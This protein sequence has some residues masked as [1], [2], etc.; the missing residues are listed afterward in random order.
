MLF[1]WLF[2]KWYRQMDYKKDDAP[3]NRKRLLVRRASTPAPNVYM[4]RPSLERKRITAPAKL[5]VTWE[6]V[7]TSPCSSNQG[8]IKGNRELS[9]QGTSMSQNEI[10]LPPLKNGMKQSLLNGQ[11]DLNAI[12]KTRFTRRLSLAE[13]TSVTTNPFTSYQRRFSSPCQ[14]SWKRDHQDEQTN[15]M[16]QFI[17]N[18]ETNFD[19]NK[20]KAICVFNWLS[21]QNSLKECTR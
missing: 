16:E 12:G 3:I 10:K 14:I 7:L 1:A 2:T 18:A 20:E 11:G 8:I 13:T 15:A 17:R 21:T 19:H 4:R 6:P 9:S 5:E